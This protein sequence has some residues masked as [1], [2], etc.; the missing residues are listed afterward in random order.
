M[1][2][3]LFPLCED[4]YKFAIVPEE[5][6]VVYA[7]WWHKPVRVVFKSP[8]DAHAFGNKIRQAYQKGLPCPC[9]ESCKT[10]IAPTSIFHFPESPRSAR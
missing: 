5:I 4:E 9:N 8:K 10:E 6:G 2:R 1:Y 3:L 7:Q